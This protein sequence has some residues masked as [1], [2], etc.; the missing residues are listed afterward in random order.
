MAFGGWSDAAEAATAA[1]TLLSDQWTCQ[2]F[3]YVEPDEFYDFTQVRPRV[4]LTSDM[5]RAIEWPTSVFRYRRRPRFDHDVI[6]F[7][8]FEPQLRWK[9]YVQ[10]VMDFLERVHAGRLVTLGALLAAVPHTR[11]VPMTGF[12]TDSGLQDKLREMGISLSSYEGP[13]GIIGVLHDAARERGLPSMSLWGAAPHY[14]ANASNPKVSLA[15]LE[16]ISAAFGWSLDLSAFARE[17]RE[18]ENEVEA[19]IQ[20]NPEASAYVARLEEAADQE[21]QDE[22]ATPLPSNEVLLQDLEDFLKRRGN[23]PDESGR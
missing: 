14:I 1:V 17:V 22:A 5:I 6:T 19:I 9:Q 8:A 13:T 21:Q 7:R 4:H 12:A 16:R 3:A 20:A 11:P 10:G 18:F 15:L 2:P 23:R